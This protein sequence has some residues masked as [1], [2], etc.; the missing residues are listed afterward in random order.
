[1]AEAEPE[2]D[3]EVRIRYGRGG[4]IVTREAAGPS[5]LVRVEEVYQ[6]AGTDAV[7][8]LVPRVY[9]LASRS[10]WLDGVPVTDPATAAGLAGGAGLGVPEPPPGT[11]WI[12]GE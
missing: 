5:G 10:V 2:R 12:A 7:A 3:G 1:M 11:R 8:D 6:V 9:V 4:A